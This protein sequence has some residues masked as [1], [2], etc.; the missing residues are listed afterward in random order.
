MVPE[1]VPAT[2]GLHVE[3]LTGD[4]DEEAF[5]R[6]TVEG[7]AVPDSMPRAPDALA[8]EV[9]DDHRPA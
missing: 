8:P 2:D 4:R 5:L 6:A 1:S 9:V 3:V 7:F